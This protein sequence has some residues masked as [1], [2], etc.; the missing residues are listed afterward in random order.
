MAGKVIDF[1]HNLQWQQV[2]QPV[3]LA[4]RYALLDLLGVAASGTA[5]DLSKIIR[6]HAA[7]Q[8]ACN[9]PLHGARILFDGRQCSIAGAALAGGMLIDS[10]DAH[11]GYK[12]TKG[13]VGCGVLPAVLAFAETDQKV[14]ETELLTRLLMG[15]EIGGRAGIALHATACDYHTSGA[16]IA[17]ASAAI[18]ARSLQLDPEKTREAVG[19]A[20]YHGPRSQMMR[21]IDH[22]TM[23]KDGSGW[24]SMAGCSAALLARDGFT[25]APALTMEGD[26]VQSHWSDIGSSWAITDQYVKAYPVCRWAQPA[27]AGVLLL[28]EKHPFDTQQIKRIEIG[29]FHESKR[30]SV[31]SPSTTEQAQYS[32]PFP[33]AAAIVHNDV[34][35]EHIDGAGLRDKEVLRLSKMIEMVEVDEYNQCFPA[36]RKSHVA[37]EFNDGR[38]LNSGTV[39]AAGDPEMPFSSEILEQKFMRFASKPLG[40]SRARALKQ[41]VLDLGGDDTSE[42]K[43]LKEFSDLIYPSV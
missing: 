39:Q 35:V 12:P 36:L 24:G 6:Q 28:K 27:I 21:C 7:T 8:F 34:G 14:S 23:L 25:G 29:T 15:Y 31:T 2:P 16:W 10:V 22:P 41:C 3:Q 18:G 37:I 4:T 9:D 38:V 19:I 33:T 43:G 40:E 11:D 5:T 30:L 42:A 26:D 32:L 13:H 1:I 17:L 20:E